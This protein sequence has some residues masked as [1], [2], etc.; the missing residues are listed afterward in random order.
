VTLLARATRI[1]NRVISE[2]TTFANGHAVRETFDSDAR[3]GP[4]SRLE[5]WNQ[6]PS[7]NPSLPTGDELQRRAANDRS[8]LI[9]ERSFGAADEAALARRLA[10]VLCFHPEEQYFPTDPNTTISRAGL[11]RER[12]FRSDEEVL[13]P[14]EITPSYLG[15][16][17]DKHL[18]MDL[19][20]DEQFRQGNRSKARIG[21]QYDEQTRT[22]T[23]MFFYNYNHKEEGGKLGRHE[24]D[25]ERVTIQ[26]DDKYVPEEMR[27][28]SHNGK[29]EEVAWKYVHKKDGRPVVYV[30]KGSHAN[31][32]SA[33]DRPIE[34]EWSPLSLS[35]NGRGLTAHPDLAPNLM[36]DHF[37]EGGLRLDTASK[38]YDVT[39]QPWYGTSV[40]WGS[41]GFHGLTS[42][43]DGPSTE[44][45]ALG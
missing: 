27:F 31:S 45:G 44:K 22:I 13:R 11:Q 33:K 17:H 24:G 1:G 8:I 25:W 41:N 34:W 16:E 36:D 42:G 3:N 14:G 30:A 19:P 18:Y 38:L 15:S 2:R 10:P 7:A 9:S 26:L 35:V 5:S 20:N 23:Y 39:Q 37:A 40:F 6:S 28:S 29:P 43:P 4:T 12:G 21:Y 32:A